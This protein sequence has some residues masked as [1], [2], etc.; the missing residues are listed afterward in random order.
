[1]AVSIDRDGARSDELPVSCS[2]ASPLGEEAARLGEFL[3][4]VVE[5]VSDENVV[6]SIDSDPGAPATSWAVCVWAT[7]QPTPCATA[8]GVSTTSTISTAWMAA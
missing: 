1:V 6:V 2:C 8:T 4:A 7:I 5:E 3:D